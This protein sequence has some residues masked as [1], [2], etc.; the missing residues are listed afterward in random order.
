MRSQ[1]RDPHR[2]AFE[3]MSRPMQAIG[4][5]FFE[6]YGIKYLLLM[7]HFSGMVM[8]EMM[9]H[10]TD[11]EHT[12]RQLKRWVATFGVSR[13]IRCDNGPPFFGRGFKELCDKYC[14]GLELTSPYNTE[15]SGAAERGAGLIKLTMKKTKEE[16]SYFEEALAVFMDT[17]NKSSYSLNQLFF[18]RNWRDH[19]L[20]ELMAEPGIKE[21]E[22]AR[23]RVKGGCKKFEE[24]DAKKAWPKPHAGDMVRG[25]DPKTKERILKGKV[26]E[27]VH[28]DRS[29]NIYLKDS[30]PPLFERS[31]V[32]KDTTKAYGRRRRKSSR[33]GTVLEE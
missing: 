11:T 29:V 24:D 30:R 8:Y 5:D 13:S 9:G 25:Q 20:P 33:A 1:A 16:G 3:Y 12:V 22:K 6:R 28:G 4:I 19:N 2:P 21:M 23:E 32:R 17:W 7:D 26:L 18:L 27:M 14:I 31:A 15:S 10:S